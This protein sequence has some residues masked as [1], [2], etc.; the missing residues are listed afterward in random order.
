MA[1]SKKYKWIPTHLREEEFNKFIL[2]HLSNG[3]RGPDKKISSYSS[4]CY[5]IRV[6]S[7]GMK[8][9]DLEIK[10]D[11]SGDPEIHHSSIFKTFKMWV[12]NGSFDNI[13]AA[14]V[15]NL[16]KNRLVDCSV[17]HGDGTNH[18]AKKGGDNIGRNGHKKIKGDKV[19]A[20]CDRNV[21]VIAPF[22]EA[23]GNC[24][25]CTLLKPCI[26]KIKKMFSILDFD[27]SGIILSLDGI[28]N[29]KSNRKSIFN[30]GMKPNINLRKCDKKR[31]GRKQMFNKKIFKERF[32]TIER[33][34]AW[35]D[36]F[37]RVISRFEHISKHFYGFKLLAYTMINLRH[38]VVR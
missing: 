31:S 34:F 38:F 11:E 36:K 23:P 26:V 20:V 25:E 13:F 9:E 22:V 1:L 37:R 32:N 19:V 10:K 3:K 5:I 33:L 29:S 27:L 16:F 18:V 17:L 12:D 35:E 21:N 30:S 4:F 24:N 14:S 15:I 2:M 7:T 28:Y 6:L 8:W